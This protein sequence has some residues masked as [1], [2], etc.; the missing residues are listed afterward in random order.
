MKINY[1]QALLYLTAECYYG[2][3]VTDDWDR[4]VLNCLL[5]DFYNTEILEGKYQFSPIKEF[6][7]PVNMDLENSLAF[8]KEVTKIII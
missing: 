4:R 5:L 8:I 3:R 2:G 1:N 7:V 6:Y